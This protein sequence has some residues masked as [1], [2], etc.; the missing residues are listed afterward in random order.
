MSVTHLI[1]PCDENFES[2]DFF[3]WFGQSL[4]DDVHYGR[5]PT[6]NELIEAF[7]RNVPVGYVTRLEASR[8]P[9]ALKIA[10]SDGSNYLLYVEYINL[11]NVPYSFRGDR[12]HLNQ[13]VEDLPEECGTFLVTTNGEHPELIT[14]TRNNS[15]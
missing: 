4:P 13:I 11:P 1:T 14:A 9:T 12:A 3:E 6:W 15:S 2:D 10:L 5:Q 8:N 7:E